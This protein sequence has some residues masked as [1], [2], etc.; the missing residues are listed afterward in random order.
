MW[1]TAVEA[2]PGTLREK[3]LNT[4]SIRTPS[5]PIFIA[6]ASGAP[7][8]VDLLNTMSKLL[9]LG[10]TLNEVVVKCTVNPAK[11]LRREAELGTL[12]IGSVAD[13]LA[14][15]VEEGEFEFVDTH[16]RALKAR[17]Q[18]KP[19]QVVRQGRLWNP[20]HTQF[21]CA[22]C[23]IPIRKSSTLCE[24]RRRRAK[25]PEIQARTI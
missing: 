7:F 18:L 20:P 6:T 25:V 10:M 22:S 17:K 9:A 19:C 23:T 24:N 4:P 8:N 14:F 21:S 2:S 12:R 3:P 15:E 16:F 5:A 11:A 13:I 1:A